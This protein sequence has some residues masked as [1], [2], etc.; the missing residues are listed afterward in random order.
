MKHFGVSIV[1]TVEKWSCWNPNLTVWVPTFTL[2]KF[3]SIINQ[4]YWLDWD[5]SGSPED[6]VLWLFMGGT[7]RGDGAMYPPD[8][9]NNVP[10]P[11]PQVCH[12]LPSSNRWQ[13][14]QSLYM[15]I[16]LLQGE[17]CK[18]QDTTQSVYPKVYSGNFPP[19]VKGRDP[20][21]TSEVNLTLELLC[22]TIFYQHVLV[23][24]MFFRE[25]HRRGN[26]WKSGLDFRFTGHD[27]PHLKAAGN[28]LN[29][30]FSN[31]RNGQHTVC[32]AQ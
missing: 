9:I 12:S 6:I 8:N 19:F 18:Q 24:L 20:H 4:R 25:L 27:G 7:V 13:V 16:D 5:G 21:Y 28:D 29:S 2:L 26:N 22:K 14:Q 32:P 3:D 1:D 23:K 10:R 17:I 31:L 11:Q 30:P 15:Q